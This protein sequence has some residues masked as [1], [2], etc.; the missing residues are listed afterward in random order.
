MGDAHVVGPVKAIENL[1]HEKRYVPDNRGVPRERVVITGGEASWPWYSIEKCQEAINKSTFDQ[2]MRESQHDVT[3]AVEGSSFPMYSDRHTV[4][5][6]SQFAEKYARWGALD[7]LPRI[8]PIGSIA[9]SQDWG[10]SI[11]HPCATL[12]VW[13]PQKGM[14][15]DD[16]YFVYREL[17]LPEWPQPVTTT[18]SVLAVA[19]KIHALEKPWDES[20][21]IRY[22]LLSHERTSELNAYRYDITKVPTA[23]YPSGI[24][25]L[26]F[27]KWNVGKTGGLALLQNLFTVIRDHAPNC[28]HFSGTAR[29]AAEAHPFHVNLT[30]RPRLYFVVDDEQVQ[31]PFDARGL[32]RFRAEVPDHTGLKL[33][34]ASAKVFDDVCDAARWLAGNATD[35]FVPLQKPTEEDLIQEALPEV[36]R[37]DAPPEMIAALNPLAQQHYADVQH[38]LLANAAAKIQKQN[39]RT[40]TYHE[41][42]RKLRGQ[43]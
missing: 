2:W 26:K 41:K 14:P 31:N 40:E 35:F 25:A 12:W 32:V 18:F 23:E 28:L 8:P 11:E 43:G 22:R 9:M 30:G 1:T 4:I 19:E 42:L 33:Q 5:G 13:R 16:S 17:V 36:Y 24:P 27:D 37:K 10:N 7:P 6:W 39:P 15:L 38:V 29:C 3:R 34:Q 20:R 21:L